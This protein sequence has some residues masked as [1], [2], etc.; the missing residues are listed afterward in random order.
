[1]SSVK[2]AEQS[3]GA[4]GGA[5]AGSSAVF[6]IPLNTSHTLLIV[7]PLKELMLRCPYEHSLIDIRY[8]ISND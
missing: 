1:M 7:I 5:R 8:H 3:H 6:G 4:D 2:Q